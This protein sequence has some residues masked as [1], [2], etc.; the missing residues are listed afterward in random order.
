MAKR[1]L[2]TRRKIS[3]TI[4]TLRAASI[5]Q[6]ELQQ[7]N[8]TR[9]S[10]SKEGKKSRRRHDHNDGTL[11]LFFPL[12]ADLILNHHHH[13]SSSSS[14]YP[15]SARDERSMDLQGGC[16]LNKYDERKET[17]DDNNNSSSRSNDNNK[18][19]GYVYD[20]EIFPVQVEPMHDDC[21]PPRILND[22]IFQ[23]IVDEAIPRSLRMY[24]WRRIFSIAEH[25][26]SFFTFLQ[27]V[28]KYE[29]IS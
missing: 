15:G 13:R 22:A 29:T 10:S 9:T 24:K 17:E 5:L 18:D 2:F 26:D 14:S 20:H 28:K 7:F 3:D 27:K 23:Q 1:N 25:G 21:D 11:I 8:T 19:E 12:H 16:F 6:G 4:K